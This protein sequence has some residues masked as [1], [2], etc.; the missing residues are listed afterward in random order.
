M[1]HQVLSIADFSAPELGAQI[2]SQAQ[3][4]TDALAL[5]AQMFTEGKLHIP[6]QQSFPLE[7][8]GQAQAASQS[9][10]TRGRLVI[11]VRDDGR[12]PAEDER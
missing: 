8:A 5:A 7:L 6:V 1:P 11:T 3:D 2:L 10:H 12:R 9:G 4:P